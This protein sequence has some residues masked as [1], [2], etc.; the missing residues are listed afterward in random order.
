M[1]SIEVDN[2][3]CEM[4]KAA[5]QIFLAIG[6][7]SARRSPFD[8]EM[9]T[10]G[11]ILMI[12]GGGLMCLAHYWFI[13][14]TRYQNHDTMGASI[15]FDQPFFIGAL[16]ISLGTG[17]SGI[18]PWYWCTAFFLG[19]GVLSM[20]YKWHVLDKAIEPFRRPNPNRMNEKSNKQIQPIAGKTGSG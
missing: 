16:L 13:M 20:P 4:K 19:I 17:L 5:N 8:D 1:A 18:L 10:A 6:Y 14:N 15:N 11:I 2:Q 3:D 7:A 9:N 12:L